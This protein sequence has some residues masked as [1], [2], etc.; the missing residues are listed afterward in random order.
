MGQLLQKIL[1]YLLGSFFTGILLQF[2]A[3]IVEL[4]SNF[5]LQVFKFDSI[6]AV[7]LNLPGLE[8]GLNGIVYAGFG[9]AIILFAF[10]IYQ[11]FIF[12]QN[13]KD[14]FLSVL[15]RFGIGCFAIGNTTLIIE[16][17]FDVSSKIYNLMLNANTDSLATVETDSFYTLENELT[18]P[19][20][21]AFSNMK[22][23]AV[24]F[25]NWSEVAVFISA[26]LCLLLLWQLIKLWAKMFERYVNFI[27]ELYMFPLTVSFVS[28][29]ST[30]EVFF[31]Y[32]R[33]VLSQYVILLLNIFFVKVSLYNVVNGYLVQMSGQNL[34]IISFF[35]CL[36]FIKVA[37]KAEELIQTWG[38]FGLSS[39][40]VIDDVHSV[41]QEV[42]DASLA[43]GQNLLGNGSSGVPGG[44]FL[45][46]GIGKSIKNMAS[47][48]GKTGFAGA[49]KSAAKGYYN[50]RGKGAFKGALGISSTDTKSM[51]NTIKSAVGGRVTSAKNAIQQF[52]QGDSPKDAVAAYKKSMENYKKMQDPKP[53]SI[54]TATKI[55]SQ[56]RTNI[57]KQ[58][59]GPLTANAKNMISAATTADN[60]KVPISK[61]SLSE[62]AKNQKA[63]KTMQLSS[64]QAQDLIGFDKS[65]ALMKAGNNEEKV[66]TGGTYDKASGTASLT[67][68]SRGNDGSVK[69]SKAL[70]VPINDFQGEDGILVKGYG[71][72]IEQTSSTA[73]I[74]YIESTA[75][76]GQKWAVIS[77]NSIPEPI[78]M[79][80]GR[81]ETEF[82]TNINED[83][84]EGNHEIA[85]HNS[86]A[87]DQ[88]SQ[89]E[90][91]KFNE[92][93]EPVYAGDPSDELLKEAL[94]DYISI[95]KLKMSQNGNMD[96]IAREYYDSKKTL[97]QK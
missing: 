43:T 67:F 89:S 17:V 74:Q 60:K 18:E 57:S 38:L 62:S 73:G 95:N 19:S 24:Q 45:N 30:Q 93:D 44:G 9:L 16:K 91:V 6:E 52:R 22:E 63:D 13:A 79:E 31:T 36:G 50:E 32:L 4:I 23:F 70:A 58:T 69:V 2:N 82:N 49:I 88:M 56:A 83:L 41:L 96:E 27:V 54:A 53:N 14:S 68:E 65:S 46:S 7:I 78:K 87:V 77:E 11:Y 20:E 75:D 55:K 51:K 86:D 59:A 85:K 72:Q 21:N 33:A 12:P 8:G 97:D 35:F 48:I 42:R 76:D 15:A 64:S 10:N 84:Q 81:R 26:L 37:M 66:C 29:G 94:V 61:S 28:N 25:M 92:N 40:S 3:V 47:T 5:S 90:I 80:I 39:G 71:Q 34:S 1:S